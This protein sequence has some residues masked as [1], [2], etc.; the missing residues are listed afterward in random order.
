M[1]NAAELS[2]QDWRRLTMKAK[3]I[4]AVACATLM[5][6][7]TLRADDGRFAIGAR[8]GTLGLGGD[9]YVNLF[10][11]L[12]LR[13]GV[14]VLPFSYN[15]TIDDIDYNF[16][17]NLR[18]FPLTLDWYPFHNPFHLS[19]GIIL[20]DTDLDI[21]AKSSTTI[22]INGTP[23]SAADAGTLEGSVSFNRVAPY[24]GIGWGNPFNS[25]GR[26]G[27]L[28]DLGV[29]FTG[30]PNVSLRA[31]GPYASDPTFQSNL[32][33]EEKDIQDKA[34]K[35]RFYPVLSLSLYYRF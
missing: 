18:T 25:N 7:T 31:T 35:Y 14:G 16:K 15:S 11:D 1:Q 32:A 33:Q 17:I 29:A 9:V 30:T 26:L 24:V 19:G 27:L 21:R 22:T 13:L 3:A 5:I 6:Q 10:D 12:N 34:D 2:A 8:A 20:N 23:Y 4:L 28:C